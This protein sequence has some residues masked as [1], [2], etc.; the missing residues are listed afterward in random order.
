MFTVRFF[1]SMV[2]DYGLWPLT[3]TDPKN[4][5]YIFFV[6][7]YVIDILKSHVGINI[8]QYL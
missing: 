3:E 6:T 1:N 7:V 8:F 5:K 4:A 2:P